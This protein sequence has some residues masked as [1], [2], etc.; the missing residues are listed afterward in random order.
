MR[1]TLCNDNGEVLAIH[2]IDS[3]V[4]QNIVHTLQQTDAFRPFHL[5]HCFPCT[6][7]NDSDDL[8]NAVL[9]DLMT[10]CRNEVSVMTEETCSTC[11]ELKKIGVGDG[12]LRA[13]SVVK[14]FGNVHKKV[15][16]ECANDMER[17]CM[18]LGES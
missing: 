6:D 13:A 7:V 12:K 16:P 11:Y 1:L 4:A 9:S 8:A 18:L 14:T 3:L 10:V 17:V 5:T 15:C 2:Q